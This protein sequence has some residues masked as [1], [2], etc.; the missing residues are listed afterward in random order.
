MKKKMKTAKVVD[1]VYL[2]I[3]LNQWGNTGAENNWLDWGNK[4]LPTFTSNN[5]RINNRYWYGRG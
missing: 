4:D 2:G 5:F 3:Y 1:R